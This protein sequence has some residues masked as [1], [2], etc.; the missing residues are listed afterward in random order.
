MSTPYETPAAELEIE[1]EKWRRSKWLTGWIWFSLIMTGINIPASFALSNKMVETVP[2]MT[3]PI[4]YT[5]VALSLV[6]MSGLVLLLK[7]KKLGFWLFLFVMIAASIINIYTIGIKTA[8]Y[9]L[10]GGV[11]LIALLRKGGDQSAW[12]RLS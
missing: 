4:V 5:L 7:N 12:S 11:I 2:R 3:L 10:I 9:G 1:D 6:S 8:L